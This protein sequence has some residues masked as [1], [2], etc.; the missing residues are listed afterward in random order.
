MAEREDLECGYGSGYKSKTVKELLASRGVLIDSYVAPLVKKPFYIDDLRPEKGLR[1]PDE[2]ELKRGWSELAEK[3]QE[4]DAKKIVLMGKTV[5]TSFMEFFDLDVEYTIGRPF[6]QLVGDKLLTIYPAYDPSIT[7]YKPKL[8]PQFKGAILGPFGDE[9]AEESVFKSK[10][11]DFEES[12]EVM[13]ECIDL[14]NKGDISYI[15]FDIETGKHNDEDPTDGM[16]P[17]R[18]E[19]I[20]FSVAHELDNTGYAFP[21]KIQNDIAHPEFVEEKIKHK[22]EIWWPK[23][24]K[25]TGEPT[26]K[27]T[28]EKLEVIETKKV[29]NFPYQIEEC[30]IQISEMQ[31]VKL[32]NKMGEVLRT[33]PIIAHNAK[34]DIKFCIAKGLVKANEIKLHC[35]TIVL[36]SM[37]Y[38]NDGRSLS[39]KN[40]TRQFTETSESWEE[41]VYLYLKKYGNHGKKKKHFGNLPT[42]LLGPYAGYDGIYLRVVYNEMIKALPKSRYQV[43]ELINELTV[44]LSDIE[45]TGVYI[46]E[47]NWELLKDA[48]TK[49]R[50]EI[51]VDLCNTPF[52]EDM[53]QGVLKTVTDLRDSRL[54]N[55]KNRAKVL[56]DE[57]CREE[58]RKIFNSPDRKQ[59]IYFGKEYFN[60]PNLPDDYLTDA[61]KKEKKDT[62]RVKKRK[63][64][65]DKKSKEWLLRNTL[66][67]N[68]IS[69]VAATIEG[70]FS[71]DNDAMAGAMNYLK[72]LKT[73]RKFI[74]R[75]SDLAR[76]DKLLSTY[77]RP[78]PRDMRDNL[79]RVGYDHIHIKTGRLSS[80]FHTLDKKSDV[81]RY[82]DSRWRSEGGIVSS[83]DYS[84][85]ELRIVAAICNEPNMIN[86]FK[87]G[88]DPH[89]ALA[90]SAL[91]ISPD[92]VTKSQRGIGKTLNFAILYGSS[93]EAVADTLNVS[94]SEAQRLFDTALDTNP[95]LK[96]W[97]ENRQKFALKYG[98]IET[99]WGRKINIPEQQMGQKGKGKT[100]RVSVNY[101]VQSPA[102]DCVVWGLVQAYK[103][104]TE[105]MKTKIFGCVHDSMQ[106]DIYPGELFECLDRMKRICEIDM[107]ENQKHWLNCPVAVSVELGTTWGSAVEFEVQKL[108]GDQGILVM[109]GTGLRRDVEALAERA[110]IAYDVDYDILE[111]NE[112]DGMDNL[113]KVF[114]DDEELTVR[115]TITAKEQEK[116]GAV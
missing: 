72:K 2:A 99:V 112:P 16:D 44:V 18:D 28:T 95:G 47:E 100:K 5:I 73:C 101:S 63:F 96:K 43:Y 62:G 81:T 74:E 21:L 31:R 58:A 8:I 42:S 3:V 38:K 77:I 79:Y 19:I 29:R 7:H 85:L 69:E 46:N 89:K 45:V 39:L 116:V 30:P 35:D 106:L 6:L 11:C 88:V 60:L 70:Q 64:S 36:A 41:D 53:Y 22:G 26:G 27:F 65:L 25:K 93:V 50:E 49:L 114:K 66:S 56:T 20:M 59:E 94:V 10:V 107:P 48:W 111:I 51:L 92:K 113:A 103:E 12:M 17:W 67:K 86:A 98:F 71:D 75:S 37:L 115:M 15:F 78:V 68:E 90:A 61:C 80:K 54:A 23:Y 52:V 105:H 55:P 9:L 33:V 1:S 4:S 24:C 40:L 76:V 14:Y 108:D 83:V 13:Q 57:E 32:E 110:S 97:I 91:G 84:Q 82:I 87:N 109:E 34:F 102:S 104:Y